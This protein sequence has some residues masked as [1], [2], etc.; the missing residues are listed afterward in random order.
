MI[1]CGDCGLGLTR[2]F[3]GLVPLP[4][5]VDPGCGH[6]PG[7]HQPSERDLAGACRHGLVAVLSARPAGA[8]ID[9]CQEQRRPSPPSHTPSRAG[10]RSASTPTARFMWPTP[11]TS[12]AATSLRGR[13]RPHPSATG[14][15]W[16]GPRVWVGWRPGALRG[17][18]ARGLAWPGSS[19]AKG[20]RA[21]GQPARAF[22][23]P[24]AG[25]GRPRRCRGCGSGGAGWPGHRD[26]QGRQPPGG[27]GPVPA[28]G[29]G[30]RRQGP[31]PG[32]QRLAGAGGD[33]PGR[34]P[35]A[36]AEPAHR[37]AGRHGGTAAPRA[38]PDGDGGDQ[39]GPAPVGPALPGPG[40]RAGR[41]GCRAGPAHRPGGTEAASAVRGRR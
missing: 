14:R 7:E 34:A 36:A 12:W 30:H 28:G 22:R 37:P 33:R 19:T 15:C 10:S 9:P 16:T 3:T 23:P 38:D 32:R 2:R 1:P 39:A 4:W 31:H 13:L 35:R 17:P 41:G 40:R 5:V 29:Q 25:Q 27:G 21:R 20:S 24:P 26:P 18:A 11:S 8:A 6:R